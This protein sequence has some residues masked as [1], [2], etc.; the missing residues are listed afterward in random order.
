MDLTREMTDDVAGRLRYVYGIILVFFCIVIG[1]LV[2]LQLVEGSRYRLFSQAHSIKTTR[3]PAGRST[4]LDRH[5]VPLVL[6]RSAMDV[7]VTP[8]ELGDVDRVTASV[9]T[10]VGLPVETVTARMEQRKGSPPFQPLALAEDVAYDVVARVRAWQT[11]WPSDEDLYDLRGIDVI[12]RMSRTYPEGGIAPHL[13][14]YIREIKPDELTRWDAKAPGRFFPGDEVGATGLEAAWDERLRG[15]NGYVERLVDARGREVDFPE[16]NWPLQRMPPVAA[17]PVTLTVDAR[18]QRAAAK[19][20]HGKTGAVVAIEPNT[21]GVLA[22]YSAP[23]YDLSALHDDGRDA[24]WNTILTDPEKPLLNRAVQSAYPPGSTYKIVTAAA[25]LGEG[26]IRPDETI[27]CSGG[28]MMGGRRFGCWRRGGHGAVNLQRALAESCDVYFYT[29]GLRVGP[30]RLAEYA[31]RF[32]L[33]KPTGIELPHERSGL[34]PTTEWK[35]R[36]RKSAWNNGDT[37]SIAIG[38][39]YDLL[40][41]LQAAVMVAT[42]A[43]GGRTVRPHLVHDVIASSAAQSSVDRWIATPKTGFAMT[44]LPRSIVRSIQDGLTQVVASPSGTAHALASL[45]VSVAGKTGTAQ[46]ISLLKGQGH[47]KLADHAWFVAYAPTDHPKIAVAVLVEHGGH[48]GA[49]AAPIAAEI[50]KAYLK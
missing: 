18:L 26:V 7:V 22:L 24:Y 45:G 5:G 37:L 49:T 13:L 32:G 30:D 15:K 12:E 27:N 14:G 6:N 50:I 34:I 3:I 21:G 1:R 44:V 48:G 2:Y 29:V 42:I 17:P 9:A 41:P 16:L 28:M 25:G 36:A 20:F 35:L 38:Q 23:S 43:N 4:L 40:T 19:A 11:A 31:H 47:G 8:Q 46:V 39:G 10:L 33:G